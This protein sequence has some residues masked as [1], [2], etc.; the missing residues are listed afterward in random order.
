MKND[1]VELYSS[2]IQDMHRLHHGRSVQ[3]RLGR[4][5]GGP[6]RQ[7]GW[8]KVL[9]TYLA[10]LWFQNFAGWHHVVR[11][12]RLRPGLAQLLHVDPK[13]QGVD[14]RELWHSLRKCKFACI[15]ACGNKTVDGNLSPRLLC[16]TKDVVFTPP[17]GGWWWW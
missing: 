15:L 11:G 17:T 9:Y 10:V 14:H 13:L 1:R 5:P 12:P 7:P 4:T 2:L 3:W 6:G 8:L 16:V